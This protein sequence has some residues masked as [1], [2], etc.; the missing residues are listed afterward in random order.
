MPLLLDYWKFLCV[1]TSFFKSIGEKNVQ[2]FNSYI[3]TSFVPS[4]SL[5]AKVIAFLIGE[6]G[7]MGFGE[8]INF[9]DWKSSW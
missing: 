6:C 3:G 5:L 4:N 2:I 1:V 7:S 9:G 8:G